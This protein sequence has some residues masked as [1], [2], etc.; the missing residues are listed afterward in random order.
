[1]ALLGV[2]ELSVEYQTQHGAVRAVEDVSLE[3]GEREAFGLTNRELQRYLASRG[4]ESKI[5]F[6]PP[7]HQQTLYEH[8]PADVPNTEWLCQ[9]ILCVPLTGHLSEA[10]VGTIAGFIRQAHEEAPRVR[11]EVES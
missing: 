8:L 3:I 11:Q 6:H 9:R 7:I 2:H 4:V 5:Y 10:D 1:M